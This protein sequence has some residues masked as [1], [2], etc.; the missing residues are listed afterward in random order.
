LFW[1][2]PHTTFLLTSQEPNES[3][4]ERVN[5]AE[6]CSP[7]IAKI[8]KELKLA[9]ETEN[10]NIRNK[11][12]EGL[13]ASKQ[14]KE[15]VKEIDFCEDFEYSE[16]FQD[17]VQSRDLERSEKYLNRHSYD[18]QY[19]TICSWGSNTAETA[20]LA[21]LAL[22]LSPQPIDKYYPLGNWPDAF[23]LKERLDKREEMSP[24]AMLENVKIE[25]GV[26]GSFVTFEADTGTFW[27]LQMMHLSGQL[28]E[29]F[30]KVGL[31]LKHP[32]LFLRQGDWK[33]SKLLLSC[34]L[35]D[36]QKEPK[37]K[38]GLSGNSMLQKHPNLTTL[39][40]IQ[41]HGIV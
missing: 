10:P 17:R 13:A 29:E 26:D 6:K 2:P 8:V 3:G 4:N 39:I 5:V 24:L 19:A 22:L 34:Y 27:K 35:T 14:Q 9:K 41:R 25:K 15:I 12:W 40:S 21:S 7:N 32:G 33:G 16:I 11:W 37:R 23:H 30:K 18:T 36:Q 1:W 31:T 28:E 38:I 20:I